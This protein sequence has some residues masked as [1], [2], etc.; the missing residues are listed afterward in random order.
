MNL[1]K[2]YMRYDNKLG[3]L[4]TFTLKKSYANRLDRRAE[5]T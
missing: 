5:M 1:S 2:T 3:I 4:K